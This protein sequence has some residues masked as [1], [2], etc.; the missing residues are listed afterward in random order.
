MISSNAKDPSSKI[1]R[2]MQVKSFV[3]SRAKRL[4]FCAQTA[5][6]YLVCFFGSI[7]INEMWFRKV[8]VL[9][10]MVVEELVRIYPY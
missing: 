4:N 7:Y 5:R 10:Q 9:Q 3:N 2:R 8:I 1:G 6:A